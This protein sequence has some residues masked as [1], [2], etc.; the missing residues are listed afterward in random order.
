MTAAA[1][2]P[3]ARLVHV[4]GIGGLVLFI[5][6][7]LRQGAG[8]VLAA[9]AV[10]GAGLLVVAAFHVLPLATNAL[11]WRR[12]LAPRS[13]G[14][15]TVMRARW[16]A[17]S[18]NGLLPVAQIGGNVVRAAVVARRGVPAPTAGASVAVDITLNVVAQLLFTLLGLGLLLFSLR[19]RHLA[20]PAVIGTAVMG[21]LLLGF[22]LSQRRG[23]FG[24]AARL[25]GRLSDHVGRSGFASGA[26]AMDDEVRRLYGDRAALLAAGGWHLA[27]WVLGA[28]EIWLGLYYLRQPVD[29][30]TALLMESLAQ[31]LR[32]AA[33]FVPGALGVQ[34]GGYL[35]IGGACGLSPEV[36]LALSLAKR[37]RELLLGVP[38]LVAWML[39]GKATPMRAESPAA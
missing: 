33:F 8:D 31:A 10:A 30:T 6:L 3:M 21:L 2:R 14:L 16:I 25:M 32:T 17:E 13:P 38:G 22:Y 26:A 15:G 24:G 20:L 28:G 29:L 23:L 9:L 5:A 1:R 27:S 18:I 39:E 36:A 11:A 4:G 12:L 19:G 35:V 34:E 7:I 37:T